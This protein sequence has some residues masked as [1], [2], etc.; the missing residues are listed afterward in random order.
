MTLPY[1][2]RQ[3]A[4]W[5][6]LCS[7]AGLLLAALPWLWAVPAP[8]WPFALTGGLLLLAGWLFASLRVRVDGEQV[9][10]AFGPGWLRRRLA[11]REVASAA[12]VRS[13]WWWGY[14]IR[15][16]PQ[17]WMWNLAGPHGVQLHLHDGRR[18]RIGSDDAAGLCAAI[19][20]AA[21]LASRP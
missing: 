9:Q 2:H 4:W 3:S 21:G 11:V 19:E 1:E 18:L 16:T 8:A 20:A 15:L 10:L 5:P 6:R 17:G 14:G 12:V 13:P 7:A